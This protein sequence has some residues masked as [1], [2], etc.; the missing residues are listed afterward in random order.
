VRCVILFLILGVL[1]SAMPAFAAR[2]ILYYENECCRNITEGEFAILYC[3]GLRLREPAQGWTVQTASAALS[4]IGHQPEG[5]WVLSRF[6]TEAVCSRLL[7][8]SAFFRK[9]FTESVTQASNTLITIARA[10]SIVPADDSLTQGE[11]AVL[12]A[13]ALRLPLPPG[14]SPEQAIQ[15]LSAQQPPIRPALGWK[16]SAR[17]TEGDMVQILVNTPFRPTITNPVIEVSAIQA[18][19]LLFGKFEVATQGQF[20]MFIVDALGAPQP[21][22]GWNQRNTLEYLQS[23]YGLTN[24]F[25]WNPNAPLCAETFEDAL[26]QILLKTQANSA[27]GSAAGQKQASPAGKAAPISAAAAKPQ[28][29]S[30]KSAGAAAGMTAQDNSRMVEDF[31]GEVKRTGMLPADKCSLVPTLQLKTLQFAPNCPT[32]P[33]TT[34]VSTP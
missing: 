21:V 20:G 2:T 11:Y 28:S 13:N 33:C 10:R 3:Q 4:A 18:Y 9:P 26:R 22:G 14:S 31:I 30:A 6:L 19:S 23:E 15:V 7:R 1:L 8:N 17:L 29:G 16:P 27:S 34:P 5:G 24:N 25:G 32:L 12:L